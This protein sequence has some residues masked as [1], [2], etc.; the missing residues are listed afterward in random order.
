MYK[1]RQEGFAELPLENF[2]I[3]FC[4]SGLGVAEE[5]TVT[6]TVVISHCVSQQ[7]QELIC[8][9]LFFRKRSNYI[10]V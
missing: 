5:K 6:S 8:A 2:P 7:Q 1:T 10:S 9:A 4:L 3:H